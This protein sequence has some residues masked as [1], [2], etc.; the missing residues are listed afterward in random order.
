MNKILKT[1]GLALA[2]A[3]GVAGF[4]DGMAGMDMSGK[5][6]G[7]AM[8]A[9]STA[10]P[11]AKAVKSAKPKAKKIAAKPGKHKHWVCPMHDGGESDHPGKCPKC[12]MDMVEVDE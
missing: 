2:L 11:S 12:G 6:K 4:A 9:T 7:M 5:D 1:M 3:P 8:P 10:K